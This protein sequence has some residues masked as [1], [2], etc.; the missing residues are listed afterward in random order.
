MVVEPLLS[1]DVPPDWGDHAQAVSKSE[2][3][4]APP[5]AKSSQA[6]IAPNTGS[7][8]T[9]VAVASKSVD[10]QS[11]PIAP[12][13]QEPS[14]LKLASNQA[15]PSSKAKVNQVQAIATP[16][17]ESNRAQ[18]DMESESADTRI[19]PVAHAQTASQTPPTP[20]DN[21]TQVAVEPVS[22][23]AAEA[24]QSCTTTN[25]DSNQAQGALTSK[26]S[27]SQV[28]VIAESNQVPVESESDLAPSALKTKSQTT[29]VSEAA[30]STQLQQQSESSQ[31]PT[32]LR[33]QVPPKLGADAL[34]AKGDAT[35]TSSASRADKENTA[36]LKQQQPSEGT[37]AE[38]KTRAEGKF[39]SSPADQTVAVA[40]PDETT[41]HP[42]R[43]GTGTG[44]GTG[45]AQVP[46]SN[47]TNSPQRS[48]ILKKTKSHSPL[49]SQKVEHT[50]AAV[51]DEQA[52]SADGGKEFPS[53]S[54]ELIQK[55]T[56]H[57][58][59]GKFEAPVPP[60]SS[61]KGHQEPP[62]KEQL[63]EPPEQEQPP[64]EKAPKQEQPVTEEPVP[65]PPSSAAKTDQEP[66]NEDQLKKQEQPPVKKE[67][68]PAKE[69]Q[70]PVED[71]RRKEEPPV[72]AE[73]Q[74]S[75]ATLE[76]KSEHLVPAKPPR[77]NSSKKRKGEKMEVEQNGDLG[78]E[79]ES[80]V[81]STP[82]GNTF[83]AF[84]FVFETSKLIGKD[85]G[86]R[87]PH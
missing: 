11:A 71:V 53:K 7:N 65:P 46:K 70:A 72:D 44:T 29:S 2:S 38:T 1:P 87:C 26:P 17:V 36:A 56:V 68:E 63:K 42:E 57:G 61:A 39:P 9:Q 73:V 24:S 51:A 82:P 52:T 27:Q 12:S 10:T 64:V 66:P 30:A 8:E 43:A 86:S 58:V 13:D 85:D 18:V 21:R 35:V 62:S 34:E 50:E 31:S 23:Q 3:Q 67:E 6:P 41:G 48:S 83:D 4:T 80:N 32:V 54:I 5:V 55:G 77:K 79:H 14:A 33:H 59:I 76:K 75:E 74:S 47:V 22:V 40:T 16:G 69:E 28:T 15:P 19:A 49:Q 81:Q 37:T 45:P 25:A 84:D 78:G 60:S 20:K